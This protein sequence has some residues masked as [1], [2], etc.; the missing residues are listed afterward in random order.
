[1][2][3]VYFPHVHESITT[4]APRKV[5]ARREARGLLPKPAA[6]AQIR[7]GA[8]ATQ[9]DIAEAVGVTA[10]AGSMWESG[11]RTPRGEHLLAYIR[12]L[13]ALL[14]STEEPS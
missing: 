13:A 5:S 6:R 10:T 14:E 8:V 1:M 11:A 12:I 4:E 7:L 2:L 3:T 9:A